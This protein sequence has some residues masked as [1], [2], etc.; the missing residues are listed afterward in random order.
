MLGHESHVQL[1]GRKPKKVP[2]QRPSAPTNAFGTM[3]SSG[4]QAQQDLDFGFLPRP[5]HHREASDLLLRLKANVPEQQCYHKSCS[6]QHGARRA[7]FLSSMSC[8]RLGKCRV[9][10][11]ACSA[12]GP[13]S[14]ARPSC[15][16]PTALDIMRHEPWPVNNS[17][18]ATL[19]AG[20]ARPTLTG[21]IFFHE[22]GEPDSGQPGGRACRLGNQVVIHLLLILILCS[23]ELEFACITKTHC[24]TQA[25]PSTSPGYS[26]CHA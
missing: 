24:T 11:L 12:C 6:I 4:H 17:H 14:K 16:R 21:K 26:A 10:F 25:R 7:T 1:W 3:P 22:T 8:M 13:V 2:P 5:P 23:V 19:L 9:T 18:Q 20:S 15:G